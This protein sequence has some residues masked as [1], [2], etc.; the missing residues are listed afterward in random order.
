M[1][2]INSIV[3]HDRWGTG[4][5]TSLE[6]DRLTVDFGKSGTRKFP[7]PD[8]F[9]RFLE[10]QGKDIPDE[11][12]D[13]ISKKEFRSRMDYLDGLE[14][15]MSRI[16]DIRTAQEKSRLSSMT[17]P[18]I[19]EDQDIPEE[20]YR[21]TCKQFRKSD[22]RFNITKDFLVNI[23]VDDPGIVYKIRSVT[24]TETPNEIEDLLLA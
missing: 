1:N 13:E 6:K 7:Y 19:L 11:I 2:L 22:I 14:A 9:S 23:L 21:Y 3:I 12:L 24:L 8:C 17:I 5:V 10:F 16:L 4:T 15:F 18:E 20:K